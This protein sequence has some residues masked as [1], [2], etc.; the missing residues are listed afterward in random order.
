MVTVP[1][2]KRSLSSMSSNAADQPT[3][4]DSDDDMDPKPSGGRRGKG[5]KPKRATT[6]QIDEMRQQAAAGKQAA[7]AEAEANPRK[8]IA[9]ILGDAEANAEADAKARDARD[10]YIKE[11]EDLH[12]RFGNGERNT[13]GTERKHVDTFKVIAGEHR[14]IVGL[15]TSKHCA[16]GIYIKIIEPEERKDEEVAVPEGD[17]EWLDDWEAHQIRLS[18]PGKLVAVPDE[19]GNF[20]IVMEPVEEGAEPAHRAEPGAT[21]LSVAVSLPET[22]ELVIADK[23][24]HKEAPGTVDALIQVPSKCVDDAFPDGKFV[25][26]I[27]PCDVSPSMDFENGAAMKCMKE[28][29]RKMPDMLLKEDCKLALRVHIFTFAESAHE[30]PAHWCNVT[31]DKFQDKFAAVAAEIRVPATA[32][33]TNHDA[34]MKKAYSMSD[35]LMAVGDSALVHIVMLTDGNATA[36]NHQRPADL[37]RAYGVDMHLDKTDTQ[38][39]V[40]CLTLGPD[41]SRHVPRALTEPTEGILATATTPSRLLEEMSRIF[42][43]VVVAPVAA[44]VKLRF[45][46]EIKYLRMGLLTD[47][48]RHLLFK[49][50]ASWVPEDKRNGEL[51]LI[52]NVAGS[53]GAQHTFQWVDTADELPPTT[54]PQ[55]LLDELE[56]RKIEEEMKAELEEA[57]KREGAAAAAN[58]ARS[59]TTRDDVSSM[60]AH[61]Q[62]RFSRRAEHLETISASIQAD[63]P[64]DVEG[65]DDAGVM[66]SLAADDDEH[67]AYRGLS[68]GPA[69]AA[70]SSTMG[71]NAASLVSDAVFSQ[72]EY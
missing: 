33:G 35:S 49:F 27:I 34:A 32:C 22:I 28:A 21:S 15:H 44:V 16:A 13:D 70:R 40:H 54:V 46:D 61:L 50:D 26:V 38:V 23:H 52:V 56:A 14:G 4:T 41:C 6:E 47:S 58:L 42:S 36:G 62:A 11:Q 25:D 7:E 67:P 12:D 37:K 64:E 31:A 72:S 63:A 5:K 65:A 71:N 17:L 59:A 48:H 45:A 24:L 43:R 1:K 2:P 8:K 10:K 60:P 29:L 68:V 55:A 30:P 18:I 3:F 69:A 66:R 20:S 19:D 39:I 57:L 9:D 51:T 53:H